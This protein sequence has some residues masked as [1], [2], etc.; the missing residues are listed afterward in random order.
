MPVAIICPDPNQ[1][2]LWAGV[3]NQVRTAVTSSVVREFEDIDLCWNV[4]FGEQCRGGI[5]FQIAG[6]E[7]SRYPCGSIDLD[8]QDNGGVILIACVSVCAE[9]SEER[10]VGEECGGW[11]A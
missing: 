11:R 1:G 2:H 4:L 6:K 5:F 7:G 3:F 10:R 9:R 8:Q